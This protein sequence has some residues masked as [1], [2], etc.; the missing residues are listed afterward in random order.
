M[1]DLAFRNS[2]LT[3]PAKMSHM[4]ARYVFEIRSVLLGALLLGALPSHAQR[5]LDGMLLGITESELQATFAA[6]HRVRKPALGPHGLR[7]LWALPSTPVS[8]LPFETTF[9][10]RDKRVNRIEQRWTSTEH[11]C[12]DQSSFATLVSDMESKYGAG[13][14]SSDNAE[15]ETTQRSVAWVAGEFDVLAHLSQSPSQCTMLV[16][17]VAHVVKDASEL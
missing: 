8:G 14:A 12:A 1:L 17:Y 2:Y 11:L 10:L 6:A 9:Y 13:L 3:Q 7:G 15:N 16:I 5:P 4:N